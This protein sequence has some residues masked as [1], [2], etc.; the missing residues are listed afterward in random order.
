MES[1]IRIIHVLETRLNITDFLKIVLDKNVNPKLTGLLSG[2]WKYVS[3]LCC[4]YT[5]KTPNLSGEKSLWRAT[6]AFLFF[7]YTYF[8]SFPLSEKCSH[9][10]YSKCF[11]LLLMK[12][13][14]HR[15]VLAVLHS[16][17]S[18]WY[19]LFGQLN[20]HWIYSLFFNNKNPSTRF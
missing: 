10:S 16:Y 8:F 13:C 17:F 2:D 19:S 9:H 18:Q 5:I 1:M 20:C 6:L 14:S 4:N 11:S 12:Y 7:I 3:F 15:A